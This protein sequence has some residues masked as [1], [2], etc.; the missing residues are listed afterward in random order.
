MCEI[1]LSLCYY[2]VSFKQDMYQVTCK[3]GCSEN[4]DSIFHVYF[5]LLW[6]KSWL[7]CSVM[8]FTR[9]ARTWP[10]EIGLSCHIVRILCTLRV[11]RT[12]YLPDRVKKWPAWK[13]AHWWL[14]IKSQTIYLSINHS[15][16]CL[17]VYL[18]I[19]YLS[20]YERQGFT[21]VA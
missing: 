11:A 19:I 16:V 3:E 20:I 13:R 9:L 21:M 7:I 4:I 10:L 14:I 12:S 1:Y 6:M 18:S 2:S 17:S 8:T 15:S 5:F